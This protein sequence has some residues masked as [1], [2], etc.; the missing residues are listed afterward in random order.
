M[1]IKKTFYTFSST[2]MFYIKAYFDS[3]CNKYSFEKQNVY[4]LYPFLF[5]ML[6]PTSRHLHT[7][8]TIFMVFNFGYSYAA[9]T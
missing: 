2:N 3:C 6:L 1:F 9:N 8:V 7:Y 4:I 5:E